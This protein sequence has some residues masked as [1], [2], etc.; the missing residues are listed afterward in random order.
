MSYFQGTWERQAKPESLLSVPLKTI[1]L[2]YAPLLEA[3]EVVNQKDVLPK[4][5]EGTKKFTDTR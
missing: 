1:N 5:T 4:R 3:L 2:A